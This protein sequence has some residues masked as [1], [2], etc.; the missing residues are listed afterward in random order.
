MNPLNWHTLGIIHDAFIPNAVS[1]ALSGTKFVNG[2][3]KSVESYDQLKAEAVD[4]YV[5]M[6]DAYLSYRAAQGEKVNRALWLKTI[7][8]CAAHHFA[9]K[10]AQVTRSIRNKD[11]EPQ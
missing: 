3:P 11:V 1:I 5:A 4:P 9:A 10:A 2:L 7:N 8:S 6:R